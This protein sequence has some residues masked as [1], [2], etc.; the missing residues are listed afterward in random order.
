MNL[1]NLKKAYVLYETLSDKTEYEAII[2]LDTLE[3]LDEN[4]YQLVIRL[5]KNNQQSS[6]Y[7]N[8]KVKD[9]FNPNKHESWK[10]NDI[11]GDYKLIKQI[12]Q[13][14]MATVFKAVRTSFESQKPVAIKKLRL[15][16]QSKELKKKFKAEQ[17]ILSKL[18]HPN[19][20][21]YHHGEGAENEVAYLVMELIENGK[22]I[23]EYVRQ[24][25]LS[26]KQIIQLIIQASQALQYAH[27]HL[28]IHR[29]IKPSNLMITPDGSL[30]VLDFGIAKL[31]SEENQDRDGLSNNKE[32]QTILALTP[33]F[34][35]PEQINHKSISTTTDIF[36][37][38]A[39]AVSLISQQQPFP[40]NRL[41]ME[42][43]HDQEH[44]RKL[45]KSSAVDKDLTNILAKA[46]NQDKSRRYETMS[47]F[48]NDLQ[49]W[50][51]QKPVSASKDSWLY[52]VTRFARR[53]T[54]LFTTS[55]VLVATVISA[56]IGLTWQNKTIKLEIQKADAVKQ[57]M[58]DSFS[59][60]DP[61]I[62]Q[63]VDLSTKDL[64]RL[65]AEKIK[66]DNQIDPGIK[67]ELY[68][69][70]ALAHGR[71]GF[72]PEAIALLNEA[73]LII[74]NDEHANAL[75]AQYLFTSGQITETKTLLEKTNESDYQSPENKA[76][77][78]RVRAN[79]LAQAGEYEKAFEIFNLLKKL[80]LN[81]T[82]VIN[83]QLLLAEMF[84]L[85]GQSERSI[86]ILK[87]LK[88]NYPLSNT[89]VL[90]LKLNSDLVQ[91]YDRVGNFSAAKDLT[92][93]NI[94]TYKK[95][96]GDE[97]PDLGMAYNSLSV[98]L[99]LNGELDEAIESAETS[100]H[101]FIKRFGK[102]SEG[103]AQ[104]YG[105]SG[106]TLYYQGQHERAIQE[107]TIAA[108]MLE[109]IFSSDHPET[110]NAMYN[111]ATILNASNNPEKALPILQH[112]YQV[113]SKTLGKNHRSTLYTQRSLAL[114]MANLGDF[115]LALKHSNE[116]I[117]LLS[118]QPTT[119]NYDLNSA[120]NVLGRV[121]FMAE[122]YEQ[123]I[124][125]TLK[126]VDNHY[127]GDENTHA[128]SL[129]LLAKSYQH[130]NDVNKANKYY[131]EWTNHLTKIYGDTDIQHLQA[132]LEW[133]KYLQQI[134]ED[135]KANELLNQIQNILI[136]NDL[137]LDE[138]QSKLK[139]LSI[140]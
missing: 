138:I 32:E 126:S 88:T 6:Q 25:K 47:A 70:L 84:Y 71:L 90:N 127:D 72:Y 3:N 16:N 49:A 111:L 8:E 64:L 86:E 48:N 80:S 73:L 136:D 20:I 55:M 57:F 67:F 24:K 43:K 92:L 38:A 125:A 44:V 1:N 79:F 66:P 77:I 40:E 50:I 97:H 58:L 42:C 100:K 101:I 17:L 122:E 131:L 75:L 133:A 120:Y 18:S 85:K 129:K 135:K 29:D 118:G 69:S 132:L 78:I 121:Y 53:R 123:A 140:K 31:I 54:A 103:L 33:S 83:N 26:T 93:E 21:D 14:G 113:E 128:R 63:G 2:Q 130:L 87:S 119:Q 41:L 5:I 110:M 45:L 102:S 76:A 61:N 89:D 15:F 139:Q 59:V 4:V 137:K 51:E 65:A 7:F 95:I 60:T 12:G 11:I 124:E 81:D 27:N 117:N 96:L 10:V 34:A 30:K 99:R 134:D 94:T 114:T 13:G 105:N 9:Q 112:M 62:S 74:P 37:L 46:L 109:E 91:Y 19:I 108:D 107:L 106:V 23:N 104:A 56:I 36:S 28:I 39:V 22:V 98:F 82:E 68:V 116:C 52:R 35:S 115:K